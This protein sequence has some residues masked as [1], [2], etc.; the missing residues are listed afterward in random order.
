MSGHCIS[1]ISDVF[2][3][4]D[5][6]AQLLSDRTRLNDRSTLIVVPARS[7]FGLCR[8]DRTREDALPGQG[9]KR[10]PTCQPENFCFT[11][12]E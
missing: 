10:Q 7:R 3:Q 12:K 5:P 8:T 4:A 11:E 9:R 6:V 1:R 2:C